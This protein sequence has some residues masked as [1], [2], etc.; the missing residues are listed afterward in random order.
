MK[1]CR[2]NTTADHATSRSGDRVVVVDF[3]GTLFE[4]NSF[5]LWIYFCLKRSLRDLNFLILLRLL[6]L[7]FGRKIFNF[8]HYKFKRGIDRI[9]YPD[10]WALDFKKELSPKFSETVIKM[11]KGLQPCSLIISTAAPSCYAREFLQLPNLR[12][13]YLISSTTV[14]GVFLDNCGE[15]KRDNTL[16]LLKEF[17]L[18]G[19]LLFFTDHQDDI[20]LAQVV[21]EVYLCD[22]SDEAFK[23]F[24][25][26]GVKFS[27]VRKLYESN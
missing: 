17:K 4:G 15:R 19:R 25:L 16:S 14:D 9:A 6:A 27:L 20:P 10:C 21:D 7:L 3:D 13:D 2:V 8:S 12:F 26:A 23:K 22:P 5:P 24:H 1:P 11:V 18:T